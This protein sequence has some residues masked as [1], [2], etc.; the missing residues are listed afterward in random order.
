M[1]KGGTEGGRIRLYFMTITGLVKGPHLKAGLKLENEKK[2]FPGSPV[3]KT[4]RSQSRGH[5]FNLWSG[6]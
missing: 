5:G 3:V 1:E 6:N 2:E 4:P